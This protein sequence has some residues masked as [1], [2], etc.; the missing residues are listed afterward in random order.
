MTTAH[1]STATATA[2]L[3]LLLLLIH[4]GRIVVDAS[5][6]TAHAVCVL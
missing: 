1:G 6:A 3:L 4:P 5:S 2:T